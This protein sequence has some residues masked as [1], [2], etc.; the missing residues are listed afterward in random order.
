MRGKGQEM[1]MM[2]LM[3]RER[4]RDVQ[5]LT[6]I[7][8]LCIIK[9]PSYSKRGRRSDP[10]GYRGRERGGGWKEGGRNELST[11]EKIISYI[12]RIGND[13]VRNRWSTYLL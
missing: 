9:G 13:M 1:I 4:E 12:E 11:E 2:S 10:S 8:P 3:V 5:T 6:C 7:F